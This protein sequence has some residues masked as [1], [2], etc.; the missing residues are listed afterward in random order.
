MVQVED[1][2]E[3]AVQ[4]LEIGSDG[5]SLVSDWNGE[6]ARGLG[7]KADAPEPLLDIA[8]GQRER[9]DA[10]I[11]SMQWDNSAS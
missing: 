10:Y 7:L 11:E 2:A 9:V 3:F 4:S 1:A 5:D 6:P 8:R